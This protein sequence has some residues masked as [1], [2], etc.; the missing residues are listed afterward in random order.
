ME[1]D[2]AINAR[3]I[4]EQRRRYR[5]ADNREP[6]I[7]CLAYEMIDQS[8]RQHGVAEPVRRDKKDIHGPVFINSSLPALCNGAL[9]PL[10]SG[11]TPG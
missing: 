8:R 9:Y 6:E 4:T 5:S 11:Y 1:D 2:D 7:Q 10:N 3:C